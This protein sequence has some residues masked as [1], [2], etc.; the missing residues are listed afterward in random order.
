MIEPETPSRQPPPSLAGA[1]RVIFFDGVCKLCNAW[2]RF[3]IRYDKNRIFKLAS[4]Q[5]PPGQQVLR[6]FGMSTDQFDTMLY[7]ENGEAFEKSEAFLRIA[8]RLGFPWSGAGVFRLVPRSVRDWCYDR[9]AQNRYRLF[10]KYSQCPLPKPD[11]ENR[12]L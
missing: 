6:Y 9:I 12:F 3:I 10:G 4:V 8:A 7:V 2:V 5:S 1:D 11:D